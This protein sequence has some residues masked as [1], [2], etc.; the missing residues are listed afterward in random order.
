VIPT[1]LAGVL[2][3]AASIGPGFV[4][5]SVAERR[6]ARL[7]RSALL[8]AAELIVVGAL[9]STVSFLV[10][11]AVGG[12][13]GWLDTAALA[14]KGSH[15]AGL[16]PAR[17]MTALVAGWALAYLGAGAVALIRY[18]NMPPTLQL[19][20]SAWY[21]ML[22]PRP[23][24]SPRPFVSSEAD[25]P[26]ATAGLRDGTALAGWAYTYTVEPEAP[27][28]RELILANPIKLRAAGETTFQPVDDQLV[29]LNG[30]DIR[31]L[32]VKYYRR[33]SRTPLS[34]TQTLRHFLSKGWTWLMTPQ[35]PRDSAP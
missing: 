4:W 30:S 8:E 32:S 19:G 14:S 7:S 29:Y 3:F 9:A 22:S 26:Y 16:H 5:V 6:K 24:K 34:R 33:E 2:V 20:H 35:Q 23:L 27:E 28:Q 18:R 13:V 10:V 1:S 12:R 11:L 31:T 15:Y 25:L 21:S 17:V